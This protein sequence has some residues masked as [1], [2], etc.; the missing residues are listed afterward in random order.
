[1]RKDPIQP[2]KPPGYPALLQGFELREC[3]INTLDF[4]RE[5]F[6]QEAAKHPTGQFYSHSSIDCRTFEVL[7][8]NIKTME[9]LYPK[10]LIPVFQD[11]D[12]LENITANAWPA[13]DILGGNRDDAVIRMRFETGADNLPLHSHDH[14]DRVLVVTSGQGFGY[15]HLGP[16]TREGVQRIEVVPGTLIVFPKGTMHTF[17][18][19]EGQIETITFHSPFVPFE[20]QD[21]FE[22]IVE[23]SEGGW[24]PSDFTGPPSSKIC[25]D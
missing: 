18:C 13:R 8:R 12:S 23:D 25:A 19:T 20:H 11:P 10:S 7:L 16:F 22:K 4:C 9:A 2:H 6:D 15:Y 5:I 14:S 17:Q 3:L 1:M 21:S 24:Y